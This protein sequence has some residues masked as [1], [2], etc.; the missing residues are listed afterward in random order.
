MGKY[1]IISVLKKFEA[2]HCAGMFSSKKPHATYADP[3]VEIGKVDISLDRRKDTR[4]Y[5]VEY[6]AEMV[7]KRGRLNV[8]RTL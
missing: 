4:T 1:A 3:I 5:Y 8:S 7:R 6:M 2:T